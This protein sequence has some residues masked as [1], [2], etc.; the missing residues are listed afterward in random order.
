M[1]KVD[2]ILTYSA[3]IAV[4]VFWGLSFVATKI[5]LETFPTFTLVFIRFALASLFFLVLLLGKGFPR[6]SRKDHGKIFLTALFE[7]GLYFIFETIGLQY[8]TA[9]KAALIIATVPVAVVI[10]AALFLDERPTAMNLIGIGLSLTGIGILVIGDPQFSRHLGG[11][12]LGDSLIIGAVVTAALYMVCARDLGK[13]HAALDITAFQMVY[14]AVMYAPAFL[15]E[16]PGIQ[17]A[18]VSDRSLAALVYLTLFATCAAFMFYNFA[19]TQIPAGRAAIFINGIPVVTGIG[20]WML[21]GE[22]LTTLQ[23]FGGALVIAAV[24]LTNT[25]TFKSS[26]SVVLE[27]T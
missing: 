1:K 25:A 16:L 27:S 17:W 11:S 10:F 4:M 8:T 5:A 2:P 18:A 6:F 7:P 21:L 3:L 23:L 24:C 12:L 9:P 13:K 20:A 22:T 26:E 19:L 14:G 15:W